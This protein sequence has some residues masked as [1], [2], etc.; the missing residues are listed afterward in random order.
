MYQAYISFLSCF[1]MSAFS[2]FVARFLDINIIGGYGYA[3]CVKT[4]L[5]IVNSGFNFLKT[6]EHALPPQTAI[7]LDLILLQKR[8]PVDNE[9]GPYFDQPILKLG[10]A[11]GGKNGKG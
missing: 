10:M 9:L 8:Q 3:V 6:L 2:F 11:M 7:F 4:S 5:P 1:L